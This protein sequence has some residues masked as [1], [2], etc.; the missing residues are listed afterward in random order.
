MDVMR[1]GS[2]PERRNLKGQG[3]D[4]IAKWTFMRRIANLG[5]ARGRKCQAIDY[6]RWCAEELKRR[7]K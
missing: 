7:P 5:L 6:H 2:G 4:P 3:D 1:T